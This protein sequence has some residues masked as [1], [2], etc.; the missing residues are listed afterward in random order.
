MKKF[1]KL[2]MEFVKPDGWLLFLVGQLFYVNI[3][4]YE[5]SRAMEM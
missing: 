2:H 5:F 1:E 4:N 3:M